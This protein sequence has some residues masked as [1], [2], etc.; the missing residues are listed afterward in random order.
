MTANSSARLLLNATSIAPIF[1]ADRYWLVRACGAGL[2]KRLSFSATR[3]KHKA[4]PDMLPYVSKQLPYRRRN[5]TQQ[6]LNEITKKKRGKAV[7][8]IFEMK[9]RK[10]T[11]HKQHDRAILNKNITYLEQILLIC[12]GKLFKIFPT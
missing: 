4:S 8:L 2:Q 3:T 6:H 11:N 10:K 7:Q 5:S 9:Q 1:Q 12:D